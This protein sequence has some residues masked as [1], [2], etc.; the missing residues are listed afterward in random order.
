M[1]LHPQLLSDR[2][3]YLLV[4][5]SVVFHDNWLLN[6][7]KGL[8]PELLEWSCQDLIPVDGRIHL[9]PISQ[10]KK[11]T[12][13]HFTPSECPPKHYSCPS[14]ALSIIDTIRVEFLIR[15]SLYLITGVSFHLHF[16]THLISPNISLPILHSQMNMPSCKLQSLLRSTFLRKGRCRAMR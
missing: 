4:N 5:R 2:N 14:S 1:T 9:L 6:L 8:L 15:P 16:Y 11:K 10:I 7:F 13:P 12:W 3:T